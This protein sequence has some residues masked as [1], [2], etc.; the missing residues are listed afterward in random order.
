MKPLAPLLAATALV[1]AAACSP[2]ATPPARLDA[3]VIAQHSG[4]GASLRGLSVVDAQIAWIG[5]PDGQVLRTADGGTNWTLTRIPGAEGLDLRTLLQHKGAGE[6]VREGPAQ[7]ND[8]RARTRA[9]ARLR[10]PHARRQQHLS[11]V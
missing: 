11:S 6:S 3:Q 7:A 10:T 1:S 4:T 8:G 2:G 9:P 5:A